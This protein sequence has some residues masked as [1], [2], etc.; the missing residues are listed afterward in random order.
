ME[1]HDSDIALKLPINTDEEFTWNIGFLNFDI[2]DE[3]THIVSEGAAY[4]TNVNGNMYAPVNVPINLFGGTVV[5]DTVRIKYNT[6]ANGDDFDFTLYK[7]DD[8]GTLTIAIDVD[9]IGNGESG[10]GSESIAGVTLTNHAYF[11]QIDVNNTD[12]NADVKI[13]RLEFEGHIE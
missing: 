11:I 5:I 9:D 10:V 7:S 12:T 1:F 13:Y 6:D 8:D 3:A 2:D 4:S